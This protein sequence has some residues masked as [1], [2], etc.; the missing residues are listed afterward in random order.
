MV[1]VHVLCIVMAIA[2]AAATTDLDV[3]EKG[4]TGRVTE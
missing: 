1:T 2:A 3:G 4:N